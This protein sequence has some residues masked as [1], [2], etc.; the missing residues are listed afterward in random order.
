MRW[1]VALILFV[2]CL[3]Q[4]G[5]HGGVALGHQEAAVWRQQHQNTGRGQHQDTRGGNMHMAAT[6]QVACCFSFS[7]PNHPAAILFLLWCFFLHRFIVLIAIL[8]LAV[9]RLIVFLLNR[10][11]LLHSLLAVLPH[12]LILFS[13]CFCPF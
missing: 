8:Q 12:W 10:F 1:F 3:C 9:Q 11:F 7:L 4:D 5:K 13:H 6:A 2:G